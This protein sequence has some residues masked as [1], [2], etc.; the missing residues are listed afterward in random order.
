MN[1]LWLLALFILSGCSAGFRDQ[2]IETNCF[3]PFET[4]SWQFFSTDKGDAYIWLIDIEGRGADD[5]FLLK[6]GI[7]GYVLPDMATSPMEQ[8][9]SRTKFQFTGRVFRNW[10]SWAEYYIGGGRKN[11]NLE[12]TINNQNY[13]IF[14]MYIPSRLSSQLQKRCTFE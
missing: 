13:L 2:Q 3:T 7:K 1:K 12:V 5:P 11:I 14:E 10:P 9:E 8:L 4:E 6:N